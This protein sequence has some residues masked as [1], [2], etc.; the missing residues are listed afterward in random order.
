MR[1]K[2]LFLLFCLSLVQMTIA[3]R[4]V[5]GVVTDA[6]NGETLIGANVIIKG[7]TAGTITDFNGNF[8]LQVPDDAKMLTISYTGYAEQ[9]VSIEGGI[10]NVTI[11]L[12]QGAVL[13]EVV[14][15]ALGLVEKKERIT[16][17]AQ[18]LF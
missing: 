10:S 15:T 18:R 9:E 13:G 8:S 6:D 16:Y 14:V 2:L 4:T 11:V 7:T 17:A 5:S 3:Q 12:S 1:L